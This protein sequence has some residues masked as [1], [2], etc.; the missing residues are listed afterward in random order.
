MTP[1][2]ISGTPGPGGPGGAGGKLSP[3][4][5]PGGGPPGAGGGWTTGGDMLPLPGPTLAGG[6]GGP[7]GPDGGGAGKNA[8]TCPAAR[9]ADST[10][11][12]AALKVIAHRK[13]VGDPMTTPL[14]KSGWCPSAFSSPGYRF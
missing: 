7:D 10:S 9:V 13:Y 14:V 12:S 11:A 1:G 6:A 2:S 5:S 3:E 4:G 8:A